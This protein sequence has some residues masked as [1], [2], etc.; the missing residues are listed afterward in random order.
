MSGKPPIHNSL[1]RSFRAQ[2]NLIRDLHVLTHPAGLDSYTQ[3]EPPHV[4][5]VLRDVLFQSCTAYHA[6]GE[7]IKDLLH[8]D[9]A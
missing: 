9:R 3:R 4:F 7:D 1:S 6:A 2:I 8:T 5:S